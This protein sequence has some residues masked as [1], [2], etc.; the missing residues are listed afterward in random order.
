MGDGEVV[1]VRLSV[2]GG[3]GDRKVH[4][5]KAGKGALHEFSHAFSRTDFGEF[6]GL[7]EDDRVCDGGANAEDP[8]RTAQAALVFHIGHI[9][10]VVR[11]AEL[12]SDAVGRGHDLKVAADQGVQLFEGESEI[13]MAVAWDL[14][15]VGLKGKCA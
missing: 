2:E 12:K 7:A 10:V 6:G 15:A 9:N 4:E 11:F 3:G 1:H 8:T 13:A 14:I 5:F